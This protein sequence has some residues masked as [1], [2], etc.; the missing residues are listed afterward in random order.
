MERAKTMIGTIPSK[1]NPV[2][3]QTY[4]HPDA[5]ESTQEPTERG[6]KRAFDLKQSIIG[7]IEN[8]FWIF[9]TGP[10]YD[11]VYV[12]KKCLILKQLLEA[13]G[14]G[15]KHGASTV[16][17]GVAFSNR[18]KLNQ[19]AKWLSPSEIG[20]GGSTLL[21]VLL[22]LM[23]SGIETDLTINIKSREVLK[24]LTKDLASNED[25][26]FLD[27]KNV[28][29]LR[30]ILGCLRMHTARVIFRDITGSEMSSV[31]SKAKA[32]VSEAAGSQRLLTLPPIPTKLH[33]IGGKLSKITQARAYK[34]LRAISPALER[35]RTTKRLGEIK[36]T[37]KDA[38]REWPSTRQI[39]KSLRNRDFSRQMRVFL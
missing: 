35:P 26:G 33:F 34:W 7:S 9:T 37:V 14:V 22:V 11:Q 1:W 8:I 5:V 21:A 15:E 17:A 25:T 4:D 13:F 24:A 6:K 28:G 39:W 12:P 3:G 23:R 30:T 29:L 38:C 18:D 27:S 2:M 20:C 31:K 16:S 19:E 32:M 36:N 10:Q